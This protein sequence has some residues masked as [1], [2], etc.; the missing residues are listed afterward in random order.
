MSCVAHYNIGSGARPDL[1][2]GCIGRF[3][4]ETAIFWHWIWTDRDKGHQRILE[5]LRLAPDCLEVHHLRS[6]KDVAAFQAS[7]SAR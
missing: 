3:D 4:R 5:N 7:S 1:P 6:V 2:E